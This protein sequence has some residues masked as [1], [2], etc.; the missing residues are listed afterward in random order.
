MVLLKIG[1]LEVRW[2]KSKKQKEKEGSHRLMK[3]D[4]LVM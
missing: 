4:G 3:L 1:R 2:N